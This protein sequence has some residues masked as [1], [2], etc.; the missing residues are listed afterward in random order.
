SSSPIPGLP[1][2]PQQSS[3]TLPPLYSS[4]PNDTMSMTYAMPP[5]Y[6][7]TPQTPQFQ[8]LAPSLS[9][10]DTP[11]SIAPMYDQLPNEPPASPAVRPVLCQVKVDYDFLPQ[12]SNQVEVREGEV[13][14]VLQRTDDDGN[15]EWLLIKRASGQVGYVPAAYC[16]PT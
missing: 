11:P 10:Y 14:G 12:G 15:P 6:D 7:V 16:R 13:I 5:M 2:A 4:V 8:P 9:A 3:S 1:P